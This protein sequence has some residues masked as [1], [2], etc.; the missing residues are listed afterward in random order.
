MKNRIILL[1]LIGLPLV[2]FGQ[3]TTLGGIDVDAYG[4][5][6]PSISDAFKINDQPQLADTT[7]DK[8][9][10]TY[11]IRKVSFENEFK[12]EEIKPAKIKETVSKI[13]PN[14]AKVGVGNYGTIYGEAFINSKR[15]SKYQYG[16]HLRHMS[17]TGGIDGVAH[18]G[19]IN[20]DFD[21]Y[22]KRMYKNH[23][24]SYSINYDHNRVY[25]Y[26][27]ADVNTERA[28]IRS[29]YRLYQG[30]IEYLS[31]KEKLS[32]LF[33]KAYFNYD[34]LTTGKSDYLESRF[35]I[36]TQLSSLL[37]GEQFE[38]DLDY[39]LIGRSGGQD[40]SS[41]LS[42]KPKIIAER[43]R[44]NFSL[45]FGVFWNYYES[46][47]EE[48]ETDFVFVPNVDF[49]YTLFEDVLIAR[50]G[51]TGGYYN[52]S[53]RGVLQQ[54]LFSSLFGIEA[55]PTHE[56]L[57]MY[58]GLK[59]VLSSNITFNA[60]TG[61]R[62]VNNLLNYVYGGIGSQLVTNYSNTD[63]FYLDAELLYQKEEQYA[64]GLY[65]KMRSFENSEIYHVPT[66]RMGL[67][68]SYNLSDKILFNAE[69]F[70]VGTRKALDFNTDNIGN[71]V[72]NEIEL[73]SYFD[74]NLGI[75]YRYSKVLSAY[76]NFT[77]FLNSDYDLWYEY[78][79][80]GFGVLG[81]FSYRF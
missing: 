11:S 44:L 38:M 48:G 29:A 39:E 3:G 66:L 80:Q 68:A 43:G 35:A 52:N 10:L 23:T 28:D 33:D 9:L 13:Y 45:G 58:F 50:A 69:L 36:G 37:K 6:K 17:S 60:E 42:L 15:S 72:E 51:I 56:T 78:R 62:K 76:V 46:F 34:Y 70:Y 71:I 53:Y 81:G 31:T 12:T 20:D 27:P 64:V 67:R 25:R 21:V 61:L 79:A 2:S 5:Y 55:K 40:Y 26:G 24:M 22:T 30:K 14:Y 7:A 75:E 63:I 57:R 1:L 47:P 59:G 73:D 16:L 19:Y 54:N 4:E 32:A 18:S 49:K 41:L 8:P 77:N 65:T 74:A